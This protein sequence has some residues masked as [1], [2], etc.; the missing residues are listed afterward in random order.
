MP[1]PGAV[2]PELAAQLIEPLPLAAELTL[3]PALQG[4]IIRGAAEHLTQFGLM[5]GRGGQLGGAALL[6]LPAPFPL[7]TEPARLPEQ[8][9]LQGC[10]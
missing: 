7:P 8:L 9:P 1:L 2:P 5:L 6:Q 4:R 10:G 3:Q